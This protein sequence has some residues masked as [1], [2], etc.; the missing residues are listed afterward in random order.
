V[1]YFELQEA[2]NRYCTAERRR[3]KGDPHNPVM[4]DREAVACAVASWKVLS[5][6]E[7]ERWFVFQLSPSCIVATFVSVRG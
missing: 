1:C 5:R 6:A 4:T 7:K 3:L 2:F